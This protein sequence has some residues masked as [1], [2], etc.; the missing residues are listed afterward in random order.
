MIRCS[1]ERVPSRVLHGEFSL[2]HGLAVNIHLGTGSCAQ[3]LSEKKRV[4]LVK[5]IISAITEIKV[6]G[7]RSIYL[8]MLVAKD[9]ANRWADMVLL[10]NKASHKSK[11]GLL[12]GRVPSPSQEKSLQYDHTPYINISFSIFFPYIKVCAMCLSDFTECSC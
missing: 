11:E 7:C 6:T 2:L 1:V 4:G 10:Y 12:R 3:K 9:L 5:S 8:L